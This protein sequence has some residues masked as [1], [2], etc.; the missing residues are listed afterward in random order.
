MSIKQRDAYHKKWDTNKRE[1]LEKFYKHYP[2]FEKFGFKE[3]KFSWLWYY[4]MQQMGDDE[5]KDERDAMYASI[6]SR[7]QLSK[8]IARFF[9]PLQVQL[10]MNDIAKTSLTH[11]LKFLNETTNF[12]E[13]MRLEFYPK[14]F[15]NK[16]P[17]TV[18]WETYKPEFFKPE[19]D[20]KALKN[21]SYIIVLTFILIGFGL[22]RNR[23]YFN[24]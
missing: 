12:H 17:N 3:D 2:Q 23:K 1:T 18:K 14:I 5:S 24:K 8:N 20:F 6:N 4:A 10:T 19:D 21:A 16:P 11:H 7:A 9:P 15:E 22:F 13:R